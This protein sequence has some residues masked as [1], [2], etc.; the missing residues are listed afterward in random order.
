MKLLLQILG[1][2]SLLLFIIY[3]S[4]AIAIASTLGSGVEK[5]INSVEKGAIRIEAHEDN[6]TLLITKDKDT[7]VFIEGKHNE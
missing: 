1:S 4:I 2:I 3:L 6:E 7:L 5:V